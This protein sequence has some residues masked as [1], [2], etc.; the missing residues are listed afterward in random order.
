VRSFRLVAISTSLIGL[1]A[2]LPSA[3]LAGTRVPV[4]SPAPRV[5]ATGGDD[6]TSLAAVPASPDIDVR[7][8]RRHVKSIA[9]LVGHPAHELAARLGA[10]AVVGDGTIEWNLAKLG[11]DAA[12]AYGYAS[13]VDGMVTG[14]VIRGRA[15]LD[16]LVQ[17]HLHGPLQLT[18]AGGER[19][20]YSIAVGE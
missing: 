14:F 19:P 18:V 20:S 17:L 4:R 13:V 6:V 3:S 2:V 11:V 9:K 8:L 1:V 12:S 15:A 5:A 7:G 10:A 16:Q